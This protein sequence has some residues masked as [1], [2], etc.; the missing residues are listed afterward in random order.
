[1]AG[2][3]KV[4]KLK[5]REEE[6]YRSLH[7]GKSSGNPEWE[8]QIPKKGPSYLD[9]ISSYIPDRIKSIG[10]MYGSSAAPTPA[11]VNQ[12]IPSRNDAMNSMYNQPVIQQPRM[13]A[14]APIEPVNRIIN[15]RPERKKMF[16]PQVDPDQEV[17]VANAQQIQQ[18][19][20]LA[21][22]AAIAARESRR[23]SSG[24]SKP[25]RTLS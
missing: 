20:E 15:T 21:R 19:E 11:P 3:D 6:F 4:D 12:N 13:Q 8:A 14:P 25:P 2:K 5:G 1:M 16:I 10:N 17:E 24:S 23:K 18:E 7:G 9:T 22:Q